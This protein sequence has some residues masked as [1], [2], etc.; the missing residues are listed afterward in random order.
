MNWKEFKQWVE[1]QGVK[2]DDTIFYID[3][4]PDQYG[5]E[6]SDNGLGW[7]IC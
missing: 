2:D 4:Y 6:A 3:T 1:K 7:E 5:M